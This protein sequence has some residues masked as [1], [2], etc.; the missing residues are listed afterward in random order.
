MHYIITSKV[1]YYFFDHLIAFY[2]LYRELHLFAGEAH[3]EALQELSV[4]SSGLLAKQLASI[5]NHSVNSL[6]EDLAMIQEAFS[7]S[8]IEDLMFGEIHATLEKLLH[9]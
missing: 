7:I 8:G 6:H 5:P 2:V 1:F 9:R 3:M 4:W